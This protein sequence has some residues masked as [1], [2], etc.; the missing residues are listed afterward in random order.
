MNY[1]AKLINDKIYNNIMKNITKIEETDR[2]Y[3]W[4]HGRTEIQLPFYDRNGQFNYVVNTAAVSGTIS[5]QF[6]G[7]KFD[8]DKVETVLQYTLRVYPPAVIETNENVTLHL[9]IENVTMKDEKVFKDTIEVN[10]DLRRNFTPPSDFK[11][12]ILDRTVSIGDVKKQR[13]EVMPGFK[14]SWYYSCH[15]CGIERIRGL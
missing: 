9:E 10:F 5:T 6:F 7:N 15:P 4:Y 11:K 1:A 14:V 8:A 2:F 3:N 12:V 13:L